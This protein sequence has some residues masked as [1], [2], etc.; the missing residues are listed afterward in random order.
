M[1][2]VLVTGAAGFL[3]SHLCDTLL[4]EGYR[5]VGVDNLFRGKLEI[6]LV[7]DDSAPNTI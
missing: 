4:E 6:N 5:V 7:Q 2:T 3:G 1:K